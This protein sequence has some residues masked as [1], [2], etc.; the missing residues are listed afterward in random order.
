M[1][2]SEIQ[3]YLFKRAKERGGECRK[4]RWEGRAHAPDC[5][6]MLPMKLTMDGRMDRPARTVWVEVKA[7][8]EKARPGQLREH[9]RMRNMGQQVEVVDSFA[10]VDEVLS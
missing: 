9:E 2:E 3:A 4:V 5:V 8:G 6:V 10:R 1:R 7:T